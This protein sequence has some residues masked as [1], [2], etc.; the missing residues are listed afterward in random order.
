MA[1]YLIGDILLNMD[2]GKMPVKYGKNLNLFRYDGTWNGDI[3]HF[4]IKFEDLDLDSQ[5]RIGRNDPI[6]EIYRYDKEDSL[7]YHW[8]NLYHGFAIWPERFSAS[9]SPAML[10]QPELREDWFFSVISFH[11]QLLQRGACVLH[12]SYVNYNGKALLFTGPSNVGKSTQA[13]LW[14]QYAECEI[15]NGDRALIRERGNGLYVY[16]YPCCGTSA[17]CKNVTLPLDTIV[18]LE[19]AERNQLVE[20]PMIDKIRMLTSAIELY[21]WDL[22]EIDQAFMVAE[23]IAKNVR[24]IKLCCLPDKGAFEILKQY[25]EENNYGSSL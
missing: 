20:L 19:Q 14:N 1:D 23:N 12:A 17:I 16:G 10:N 8:G 4:Q 9:F 5:K 24:V 2:Y 3:V 22:K 25:L 21:P 6:Y 18:I 13:D 11:H 15:I 7:V